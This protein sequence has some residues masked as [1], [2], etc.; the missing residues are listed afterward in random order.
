MRWRQIKN[1]TDEVVWAAEEYRLVGKGYAY[2]GGLRRSWKL[3][4]WDELIGEPSR[5]SEG[6]SDAQYHHD[7]RGGLLRDNQV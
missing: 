7:Q 3:Y 1:A 6:K 4:V 2:G 5:F